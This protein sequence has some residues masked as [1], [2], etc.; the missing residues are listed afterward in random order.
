MGN[1]ELV[2]SCQIP[3]PQ[4][5]SANPYTAD[6]CKGFFLNLFATDSILKSIQSHEIILLQEL[7]LLIDTM[8][9]LLN[10]SR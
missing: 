8:L 4:L 6:M 5:H 7:L 2:W 9:L 1:N 10:L 3:Y